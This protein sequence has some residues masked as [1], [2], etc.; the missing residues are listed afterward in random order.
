MK[1]DY[2]QS[3][4]IIG[5]SNETSRYQNLDDDAIE[6]YNYGNEFF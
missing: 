4:T 1:F 2:S 3:Q 6:F 5:L